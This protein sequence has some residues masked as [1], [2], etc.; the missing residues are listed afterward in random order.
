MLRSAEAEGVV[1]LLETVEGMWWTSGGV[2][3]DRLE[4]RDFS[5]R[6]EVWT[7]GVDGRF[8]NLTGRIPR[9]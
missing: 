8:T 9:R 2:I 6:R 3:I 5:E 7:A 1:V 4:R